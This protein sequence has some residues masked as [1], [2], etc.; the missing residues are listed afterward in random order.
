VGGSLNE[1][2]AQIVAFFAEHERDRRL[3]LDGV[4]AQFGGMALKAASEVVESSRQ[5]VCSLSYS[6]RVA[7]VWREGID[8]GLLI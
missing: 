2:Q 3:D 4:S 7:V 6:G 5:F 8:D 1:E